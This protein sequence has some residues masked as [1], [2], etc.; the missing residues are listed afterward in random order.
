MISAAYILD[1]GLTLKDFGS[2]FPETGEGRQTLSNRTSVHR[3]VFRILGEN[4]GSLRW[5]LT[6]VLTADESGIKQSPRLSSWKP[7]FI[8][9]G[10]KAM[11][12]AC[13]NSTRLIPR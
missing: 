5:F 1:D 8:E 9:T 3:T 2:A 13:L 10:T 7:P 6:A 12:Y 11:G 4:D